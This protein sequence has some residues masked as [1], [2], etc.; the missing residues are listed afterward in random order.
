MKLGDYNSTDEIMITLELKNSDFTDLALLDRV[1]ADPDISQAALADEL[2]LAI[3]TVNGRL[4][5]LVEK[6]YIRV[7]RTLRRK[8]RYIIT[9]EGRAL[10]ATLME[11]YIRET[12]HLFQQVRQQVKALLEELDGSDARAVRLLGSGDVAD[13]CRLTCVEHQ[14]EL[15]EDLEAPA[16]V[17]DGLEISIAWP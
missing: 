16:L 17:V 4:Q 3:G 8:L 11:A 1:F 12:M 15:T 2:D 9:P 13:V 5:Q 6:G 7:E 14:V 10:R